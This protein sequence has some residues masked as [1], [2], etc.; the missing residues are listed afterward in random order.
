[1]LD[2]SR[3]TFTSIGS[4]MSIT[5]GG[6]GAFSSFGSIVKSVSCV[7]GASCGLSTIM[8]TIG[9]GIRSVLNGSLRTVEELFGE[10]RFSAKF[11]DGRSSARGK[12]KTTPYNKI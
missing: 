11:G 2:V 9:C 6:G 1:M 8:V 7:L 10:N 5:V 3:G 12:K 4:S